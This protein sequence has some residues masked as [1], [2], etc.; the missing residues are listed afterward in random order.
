FVHKPVNPG[1]PCIIN[2]DNVVTKQLCRYSRFLCHRDVGGASGDDGYMCARRCDF[3]FFDAD[4][5]GCL[6]IYRRRK[7]RTHLIKH[8]LSRPGTYNIIVMTLHGHEDCPDLLRSL[9]GTVDNLRVSR[10]QLTVM[11]NAGEPQVTIGEVTQFFQCL[12][13]TYSAGT[14]APEYLFKLF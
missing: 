11:V 8:L 12:F 13:H 10:P 6:I 2:P 9:A 3:L 4:D 7:K 5:T 1:H 14:N